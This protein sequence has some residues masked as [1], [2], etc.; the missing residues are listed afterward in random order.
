MPIS[1]SDFQYIAGLVRAHAAIVLEPGKEYLVE[2]RLEPIARK[3]GYESLADMIHVLRSMPPTEWLHAAVIDAL[4]TNETLFFRD[5]HPFEA[6]RQTII[7]RII[8]QRQQSRQLTLWSA[9][10]SSGQEPY[11]FAMMI[12]ES[13]PQLKDWIITIVGSDISTSSLAR[14][15]QAAYS[16]FE[17]NRGLPAIYMAKYFTQK[18]GLWHLKDE[19]KRMVQFRNQNLLHPWPMTP[20][21]DIILLRNVMIYFDIPA[22]Q[23]ILRRMRT[24]LAPGGYMMLGAAETTLNIDPSW[25][26]IPYGHTVAYQTC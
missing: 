8:E 4:T 18:D 1:A 24:T 16:Q 22:K 21:W 9:A 25:K 3:E 20:A 15:R 12:R 2:T 10:C 6:M 19:I 14:A 23:G 26:P 7:P 5:F 13:F 17:V 11:S